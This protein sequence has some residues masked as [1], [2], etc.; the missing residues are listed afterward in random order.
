M[1]KLKT[2]N[3]ETKFLRVGMEWYVVLKAEKNIY[4]KDLFLLKSEKK[5]EIQPQR[6]ARPQYVHV[7][8]ENL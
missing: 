6:L 2:R 5:D 7:S 3:S 4:A 8:N 1:N